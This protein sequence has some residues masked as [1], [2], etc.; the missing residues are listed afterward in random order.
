MRVVV[1]H[2]NSSVQ[3]PQFIQACNLITGQRLFVG[4]ELFHISD[5]KR[6]SL[7]WQFPVAN[8][9]CTQRHVASAAMVFPDITTDFLTINVLYRFA[10]RRIKYHS[11]MM[12]VPS[13]SVR[14][15]RRRVR[16]SSVLT[17]DLPV[18]FAVFVRQQQ[19]VARM[20]QSLELI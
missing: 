11:D 15:W 7:D 10:G 6:H 13:R 8:F 3:N 14:N 9:M 12:P 5:R 19:Y 16:T 18:R 17:V 1:C 20:V 4:Q 2:R